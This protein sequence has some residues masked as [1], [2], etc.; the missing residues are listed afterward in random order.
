MEGFGHPEKYSEKV[1]WNCGRNKELIKFDPLSFV[2]VKMIPGD[3]IV[4]P[5]TVSEVLLIEGVAAA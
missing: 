2:R 4:I 3:Y 1:F 5:V